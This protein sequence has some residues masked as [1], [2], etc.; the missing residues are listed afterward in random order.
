[1]AGRIQRPEAFRITQFEQVA[2]SLA[3]AAS[4]YIAKNGDVNPRLEL[5]TASLT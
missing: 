1:M 4:L 2:K 5:T 3:V